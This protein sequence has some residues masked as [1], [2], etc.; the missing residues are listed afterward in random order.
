LSSKPAGET[1]PKVERRPEKR[2]RSLLGGIIA[3]TD[4][5]TFFDCLIRNLSD[6]GAKLTSARAPA[7]LPVYFY[8]INVHDRIIYD[9]MLVWREGKDIGVAFNAVR[10]FSEINNPSLAFLA[11]LWLNKARR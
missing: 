8:L 4:G 9:A 2:Q 11:D 7:Q 6:G 10:R 1:A 3:F 5:V